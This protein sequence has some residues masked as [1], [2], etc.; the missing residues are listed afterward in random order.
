MT[1]GHHQHH[2]P[3]LLQLADDAI[4][5]HPIPPQ[6]KLAGS[7]RLAEI[8]RVFSRRDPRIHV[9]EDF[10]LD[11]AVELLEILQGSMIVFNG[12]SQV[13]SALVGW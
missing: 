6:S 10:P 13:L 7:K 8:T 5:A 4:I 11:R 12:P 3:A 1:H 2:Q 9:I